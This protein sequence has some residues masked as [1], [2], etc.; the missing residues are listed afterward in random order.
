MS[1]AVC[2][3]LVAGAVAFIAP[4]LLPRLTRSGVSPWFGI[5]AWLA[6]VATV[7][8]SGAVA[9]GVTGFTLLSATGLDEGL[10]RLTL[11][12]CIAVLGD[13]ATGSSGRTAQFGVAALALAALVPLLPFGLLRRRVV[14]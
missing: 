14:G 4:R 6:A 5:V 9:A 10:D 3:T 13:I 12:A 11:G 8:L 1:V 7:F 2:L